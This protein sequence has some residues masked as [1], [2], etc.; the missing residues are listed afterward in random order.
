MI[1]VFSDLK[2]DL[3]RRQLSRD[4]QPIKL[5]KLGFRVLRALVE[6]APAM[7]KHDD[8][9]SQVWGANRVITPENLSQRMK[10]LRQSLGDDPNH[11]SYIEGIRGQGF[12]LI[13]EVK[14]Q[15]VR[16][17]NQASKRVWTLGLVGVLVGLLIWIV[18]DRM[19]TA[20]SDSADAA[21]RTTEVELSNADPLQRPA[22]A[23]LP[24]ANLSGDP[25]NQYFTDGI[26]DDLLTRIS[27]IQ[28]IKTISRTSVM[29]YR[30][31]NKKLGTI[32]KELG[33][34]TILEGGVQRAGEQVRINLQL[35][36][37]E[38]DA[39]LWAGTYTRELTATNVFVIQAEIT[40]AVAS[41]LQTILTEDERKRLE[42]LPTA[43][44]EAL[45]AYFK[46]TEFVNL[47][48]SK[49][50]EQAIEAYQL[51]IKLDP[52]FALAYSALAFAGLQQVWFSGFP[53]QAQLEKSKHLIDQAI[54]LDP[55]SSE[56]FRA[57]GG[58]YRFAGDLDKAEQ[59]FDQALVLRPNNSDALVS[60]AMLKQWARKDS[61]SAIRLF[62]RAAELDPQNMAIKTEIAE[63]M[64]YLGLAEDAIKMLENDLVGHP[65]FAY[66]YRVLGKLY[67]RIESRHDK[68]VKTL[69]RAYELD[70]G[71]LP[72]AVSN[73]VLHW[74][75][76]DYEN[77]ALWMNHAARLAPGSDGAPVYR[78]WA[79]I[80]GAD[81]E[82]AGREL[83]RSVLRSQLYWLAVFTLARV[84]MAAGHPQDA[85]DRYMDY[86]PEFDGKK[87][88]K[89]FSFGVGAIHAYLALGE[90]KKA[91]ALEA[92]LMSVV[93]DSPPINY[94][95]SEILDA[96][97]YSVLG[98]Q[99][100]ALATLSEWVNQGG[101]SAFLQ[102]QTGFELNVLAHDPR[103][104]E[105]LQTVNSRLTK[106]LANLAR[107]EASG[108]MLPIPKEVLDP[109]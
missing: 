74:R 84:D 14:I 28:N 4:G 101:A 106:Q 62:R 12:R 17:P 100:T 51:A 63:V 5:T 61:A 13:P 23:V 19:V 58:W 77:T 75:L 43:N 2:F 105:L 92:K 29:T 60:Y 48:T 91:R 70:P 52:E 79:Y 82:N 25:S 103:Y 8:L 44:L 59:A 40:E 46:G 45:D 104:Q 30:G 65:D 66:G 87:T 72:N 34:S 32:A 69:R 107:W 54:L 73:A 86:L 50:L 38:S 53:Y 67:S 71:N 93:A 68:A 55:Q 64:S 94:T 57:L 90:Q 9:I 88:E 109:G 83:N 99:E 49:G 95:N 98:R 89:D 78:T 42:K 26:H 85:I 56:A 47:A 80:N 21:I 7:I 97:L 24:F 10:V 33:V 41:A 11:P 20:D 6:A 18:V 1:Y 102:I 81:F 35:I 96:S 27:N 108:E 15:P 3:D 39:H 36:D 22:I 37:A 16:K 31:S 76:G